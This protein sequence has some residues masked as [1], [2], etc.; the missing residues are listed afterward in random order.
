MKKNGKKKKA[1]LVIDLRFSAIVVGV[2]PFLVIDFIFEKASK[3]RAV[4]WGV[5]ISKFLLR[6]WPPLNGRK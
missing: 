6:S 2:F 1:N 5:S 4:A 3:L